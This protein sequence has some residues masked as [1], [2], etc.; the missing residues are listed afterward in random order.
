MKRAQRQTIFQDKSTDSNGG[1]RGHSPAPLPAW[2]FQ[3]HWV[4]PR[5]F[6]HPI[7]WLWRSFLEGTGLWKLCSSENW[8]TRPCR[9]EKRKQKELQGTK[10][11]KIGAVNPWLFVQILT[12]WRSETLLFLRRCETSC[13]R[14]NWFERSVQC[15]LLRQKRIKRGDQARHEPRVSEAVLCAQPRQR[16]KGGLIPIL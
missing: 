12:R 16:G 11:G 6:V 2:L 13:R 14:Q 9:S 5:L 1:Q 10:S 15:H 3:S 4:R 8:K 7:Q